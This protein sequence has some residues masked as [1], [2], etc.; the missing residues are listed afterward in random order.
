ME[1]YVGTWTSR[2]GQSW[3]MWCCGVLL[4]AAIVAFCLSLKLDRP[5]W[6][7]VH[8]GLAIASLSIGL[9]A[10][11]CERCGCRPNWYLGQR[12]MGELFDVM[13]SCPRC[14]FDGVREGK[15]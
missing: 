15:K 10:V 14:G 5:L 13:Q 9:F 2:T 7:A 12:D 4:A 11:R 3:K 6:L 8:L 1:R